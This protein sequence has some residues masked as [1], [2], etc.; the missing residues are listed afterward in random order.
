MLKGTFRDE[1]GTLVTN[2]VDGVFKGLLTRIATL[3]K[4]MKKREDCADG[5]GALESQTDKVEQYSRRNC[6]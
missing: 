4:K 5:R 1:I 2:I 6:L 3:E